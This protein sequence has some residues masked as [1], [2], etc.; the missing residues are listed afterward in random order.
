MQEKHKTEEIGQEQDE[1][2]DLKSSVFTVDPRNRL[3]TLEIVK[4]G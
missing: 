1:Y 2:K 3:F 4:Q